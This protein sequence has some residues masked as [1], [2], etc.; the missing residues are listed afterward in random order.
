MIR[1]LTKAEWDAARD[2]FDLLDHH[3][4]MRGLDSTVRQTRASRLYL[5]ACARAV[6]ERLPWC[7]QALIAYAERL[8]DGVPIDA[9]LRESVRELA[10]EFTNCLGESEDLAEFEIRLQNLDYPFGRRTEPERAFEPEEWRSLSHLVYL[11]LSGF[12]PNYRRIAPDF[13]AM[14]FL[15][16]LFPNPHVDSHIAAEWRTRDVECIARCMYEERDFTRL[17]H[18]ADAMQ[19]VGCANERIL[20]HCRDS[21]TIHVRGCWVVEGILHPVPLNV[22]KTR[23]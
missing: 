14:P 20:E 19:D 1:P 18:L 21:E 5:I 13:H 10:E 22:F 8:V 11:P 23:T 17:P 4:P 6:W 2:P 15:R 9:K 16:D 7:G 3:F 12:T